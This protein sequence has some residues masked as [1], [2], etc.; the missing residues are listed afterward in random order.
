MLHSFNVTALG[1][2]RTV[3]VYV[4]DQLGGRYPVLY[5]HDGQNVFHDD[6]AIGG[7]SLNLEHYLKNNETGLIVVAIESIP[8]KE[9]RMGEY[10]PWETGLYSKDLTGEDNRYGGN[11]RDYAEFL[12]RE[13]KPLVDGR[14]PTIP[15]QTY[16]GG[17]S[18]G[19]LVSLY[20]ATL[21]PTVITGCFGISSA[22]FRNQEELEKLLYN[23]EFGSVKMYFD[24]GTKEDPQSDR[25]STGFLNSNQSIWDLVAKKNKLVK[26]AI[27]PDAEHDYRFFRERVP[28]ILSYL[29]GNK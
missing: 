17:I 1:H 13:L 22:F 20:I 14:F 19:G 5:M 15:D 12:V 26:T 4:P 6:E 9:G 24:C 7:V 2:E 29:V 21:Y 25:T 27:I 18:L 10:C 16:I 28:G 8:T 3:K 11:G 23:S